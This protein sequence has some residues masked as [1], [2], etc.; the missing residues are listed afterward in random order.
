MSWLEKGF[1]FA[2]RVLAN[3]HVDIER[4]RG[5]G[6]GVGGVIPINPVWGVG[7]SSGKDY[8]Q[9]DGTHKKK[10]KKQRRSKK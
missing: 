4:A 6:G 9:V 2:K 7:G 8:I 1:I 5:G 10:L 3:T